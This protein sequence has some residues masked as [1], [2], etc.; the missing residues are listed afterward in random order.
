MRFDYRPRTGEELA[1]LDPVALAAQVD[2]LQILV[3]ALAGSTFGDPVASIGGLMD[4]LNLQPGAADLDAEAVEIRA[5]YVAG[6]EAAKRHVVDILDSA[7][8]QG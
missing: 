2:T 5:R 3:V 4:D 6:F 8:E 7:V 1:S